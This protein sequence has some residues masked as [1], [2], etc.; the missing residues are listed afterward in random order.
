MLLNC[1]VYEVLR[2][3]TRVGTRNKNYNLGQIA[4]FSDISLYHFLLCNF[5][6]LTKIVSVCPLSLV[7][8]LN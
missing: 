3:L 7:W 8:L 6:T 2:I 1:S 4:V 5:F